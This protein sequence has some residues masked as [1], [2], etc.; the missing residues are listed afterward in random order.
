ML[1]ITH[2]HI[3]HTHKMTRFVNLYS[4]ALSSFLE[5][6]PGTATEN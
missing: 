6:K 5:N 3:L 2:T 1:L 4:L